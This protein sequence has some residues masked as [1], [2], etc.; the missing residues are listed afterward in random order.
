MAHWQSAVLP[1]AH[2]RVFPFRQCQQISRLQLEQGRRCGPKDLVLATSEPLWQNRGRFPTS[3]HGA[4]AF[5]SSL[6]HGTAPGPAALVTVRSCRSSGST[7]VNNQMLISKDSP[8]TSTKSLE[9]IFW[10]ECV[11]RKAKTWVALGLPARV[12][13]LQRGWGIVS[14]YQRH[15]AT[16]T[17]KPEGAKS[18][19]P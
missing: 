2:S 1:N 15:Q 14:R 17:R 4:D 12:H 6:F 9:S 18:R 3:W 11:L 19:S 13:W 7:F 8:T 5:Q 10:T 16:I